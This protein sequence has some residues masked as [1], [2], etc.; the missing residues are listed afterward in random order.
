[1]VSAELILDAVLVSGERL[2]T[3]TSNQQSSEM[4]EPSLTPRPLYQRCS[5]RAIAV[6]PRTIRS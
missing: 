2:L 3:M 4:S 1:M 5:D 6:R